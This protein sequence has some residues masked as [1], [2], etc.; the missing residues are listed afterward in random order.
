ML[1]MQVIWRSFFYCFNQNDLWRRFRRIPSEMRGYFSAISSVYFHFSGIFNFSWDF[2]NFRDI[3]NSRDF[4]NVVLLDFLNIRGFLNVSRFSQYSRL[5]H[6]VGIFP[7]FRD[8]LNSWVFLNFQHFTNKFS[9][10][11]VIVCPI[12]FNNICGYCVLW[13]TGTIWLFSI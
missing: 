11:A 13:C 8:L 7:N 1:K 9:K 2:L 12:W 4:L 10:K 5:S 3:L 6:C